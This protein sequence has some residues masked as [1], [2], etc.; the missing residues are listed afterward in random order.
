MADDALSKVILAPARDGAPDF[1][2]SALL[3][4]RAVRADLVIFSALIGETDR[5]PYLTGDPNAGLIR[6]QWWLDAF[7][8]AEPG[9]KT[10][11]PVADAAID[12]ASRRGISRLTLVGFVQSAEYL[13]GTDEPSQN[14][15]EDYL[16]SH[17]GQA[18]EIWRRLRNSAAAAGEPALLNL[19]AS[20][21]GRAA[22]ARNL[23][24]LIG[25]G[26]CPLPLSYFDG[27]DPRQAPEGEARRAI[28]SAISRLSRETAEYLA[29][30][31]KALMSEDREIV[32]IVLPLALVEPVFRRLEAPQADILREVV[33]ISPISRAMRLG[34]ASVRARV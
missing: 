20:A 8:K 1:Y 15:F 34:L 22:L 19:A 23:V 33:D 26:R 30:A 2:V 9:T 27:R 11:H 32:Q 7:E 17:A 12:L 29:L 18:F 5:I 24:R 4:P 28:A 6:L 14:E 3:A 31:R 13:L 10:G 21:Y 16:S 25:K